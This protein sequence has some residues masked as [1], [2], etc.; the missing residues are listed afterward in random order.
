M[1]YPVPGSLTVNQLVFLEAAWVTGS[2][3]DRRGQGG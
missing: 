2:P 1:S 3:D